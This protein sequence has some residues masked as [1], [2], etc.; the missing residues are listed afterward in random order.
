MKK[1]VATL[2]NS[3][4]VLDA[5]R[6]MTEKC[7]GC[8]V[9]MRDMEPLGILT[10][11]DAL[12]AIMHDKDALS[13]N[14]GEAMSK[15]LITVDPETRVVE[16]L[17]LM[18]SKNIR[19][20]PVVSGGQLRGIMT[21]HTALLNWALTSNGPSPEAARHSTLRSCPPQT[22]RSSPRKERPL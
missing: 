4:T 17:H 19:H 3:G 6:V 13:H 18:K 7:V 8:I 5:I 1:K 12:V 10:E 16:A 2:D 21:I 11:R 14:V 22:H 15:P 20:L 9:I